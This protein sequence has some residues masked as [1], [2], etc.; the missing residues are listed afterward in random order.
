MSV[1][2]KAAAVKIDDKIYVG[3]CHADCLVGRSSAEIDK[4]AFGFMTSDEIFVGREKA[5]EIAVN[6]G[7]IT[8]R[9]DNA[10]VLISEELWFYGPYDWD[11]ENKCYFKKILDCPVAKWD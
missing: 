2:I 5:G 11:N 6:A 10:P 1:Y 9:S 8:H 3:K 7:Q 4:A